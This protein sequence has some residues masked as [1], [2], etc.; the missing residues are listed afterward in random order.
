MML[1]RGNAWSINTRFVHDSASTCPKST[2][3][4]D[5]HEASGRMWT[6]WT[7]PWTPPSPRSPPSSPRPP[8]RRPPPPR[9]C[10]RRRRR[11]RPPPLP[12]AIEPLGVPDGH[13][14]EA[15][16]RAATGGPG[17]RSTLSVPGR[18]DCAP[19]SRETLRL[20]RRTGGCVKH[21]RHARIRCSTL[22]PRHL[23]ASRTL[24]PFTSQR[25]R[26]QNAPARAARPATARKAR[27]SSPP[28]P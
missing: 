20:G 11:A 3:V 9:T 25:A 13:D 18:A 2:T 6:P 23:Y 16:A 5:L 8:P 4:D 7:P 21:R 1:R 19:R 27:F 17:G 24:V 12:R 28:Q 22:P 15:R 26:S 14:G 10:A